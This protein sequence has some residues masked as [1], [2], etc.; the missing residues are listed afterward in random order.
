MQNGRLAVTTAVTR[1][2]LRRERVESKGAKRIG[3]ETSIP[4]RSRAVASAAVAV[5]GLRS[6]RDGLESARP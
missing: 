5:K 3:A 1:G 2:L 6:L 4:A